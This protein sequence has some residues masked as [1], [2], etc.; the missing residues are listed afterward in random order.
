V[1]DD[2]FTPEERALV[3]RLG[4]AP[5]PEL[6]STAFESIRARMLDAMDMPY[7]T[8]GEAVP[9]H[10]PV[11]APVVISA[12][13]ILVVVVTVIIIAISNNPSPEQ[14]I[15]APSQTVAPSAT[16]QPTE[17]PLTPTVTST[18][19][20]TPV[21]TALDAAVSTASF[22]PTQTPT[23]IH[24]AVHTPT[25]TSTATLLSVTPSATLQ[26][27]MVIEGP[28]QNINVNVITIYDIDITLDPGDPLLTVI[29]IGDILRVEAGYN[30]DLT[31]IVVVN[32]DYVVTEANDGVAV[33]PDTGESWRDDGNCNNPPPPW[34]PAN[35]WR[36]RCEG[37]NPP[38]NSGNN[39]NNGN[40]NNGNNSN[41]MGRGNDD[42]D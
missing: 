10:F 38:G 37:G 26:T 23:V 14:P 15:S 34:A 11:S 30:S 36:R 27:V 40:G 6:D 16:I 31:V 3:E 17:T 32:I 35:G 12:A 1:N 28:V 5:Q 39:G 25:E 19:T 8:G 29:E 13:A 41:G 20:E 21:V 4:R 42:D 33:N 7:P 24:T 22:T 2:S 18:L 9:R